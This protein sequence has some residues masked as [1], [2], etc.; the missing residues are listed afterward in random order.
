MRL[1]RQQIMRMADAIQNG[2]LGENGDLFAVEETESGQIRFY[3]VEKVERLTP[4]P[5]G[6]GL[7]KVKA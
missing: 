6:S 4:I 2:S 3:T 7:G 5:L 1:T